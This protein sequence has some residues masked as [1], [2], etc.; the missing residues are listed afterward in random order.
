MNAFAN[1]ALLAAAIPFCLWATYSDLRYLKIPNK[2]VIWMAGAFL[3]IGAMV[4]PLDI[5]L[6]RLLGGFIVLVIGF[7]MFSLGLFG[8]GDAKFAASMAL[9]VDHNEIPIFLFILALVTFSF[10]ITHVI[11]GKLPFARPI[12]TVWESWTEKSQGKKRKVA[13]G[14]GMGVALIYY[15]AQRTFF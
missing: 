13:M 8:G 3:I 4:L 7:I 11:V 5:Y 9:F 2:A 6:W 15:L 10:I 1:P 12:T 14:V